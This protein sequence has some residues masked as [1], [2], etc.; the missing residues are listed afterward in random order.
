MFHTV[1][2]SFVTIQPV[3]SDTGVM[4]GGSSTLLKA[5]VSL[6]LSRGCIGP[7]RDGAGRL[8]GLI[9]PDGYDSGA[10]VARWRAFQGRSRLSGCGGRCACVQMKAARSRCQPCDIA[11]AQRQVESIRSRSCRAPRVM[12]AA[13]CRIR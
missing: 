4:L 11:V 8:V 2:D 3:A 5:C 6:V 13:T 10:G 12:R 7:V 9:M 1:G